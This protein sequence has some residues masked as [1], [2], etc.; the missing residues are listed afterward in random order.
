MAYIE[1]SAELFSYAVGAR[2]RLEAVWDGTTALQ[3]LEVKP[4]DPISR[5]QCGV[6]SL[7]IARE[8]ADYGCDAVFVEGAILLDLAGV[9]VPDQHCWVE[10]GLPGDE[11]KRIV[12]VTADQY[13]TLDG[14]I[15]FVGISASE[16]SPQCYVRDSEH[17]HDPYDIPHRKLLA[18]YT[19]LEARMRATGRMRRRQS[20]RRD[21]IGG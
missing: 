19:I 15:V 13:G 18:R 12:D 3:G 10:V 7:W 20:A 2:S 14:S 9:T 6:A 1:H 16:D 8:L 17:V 11:A 21:G 4:N 5:G